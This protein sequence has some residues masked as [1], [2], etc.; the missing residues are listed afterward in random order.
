[1]DFYTARTTIFN[2][3]YRSAAVQ[4]GASRAA[5]LFQFCIRKEFPMDKHTRHILIFHITLLVASLAA[6]CVMF[7]VPLIGNGRSPPNAA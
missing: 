7:L 5:S 2:R 6:F 4:S 1:M 3:S